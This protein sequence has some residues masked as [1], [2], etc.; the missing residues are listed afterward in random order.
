LS[1]FLVTIYK[2]LGY[3]TKMESPIT[4]V[5]LDVIGVLYVD[6]TDLYIMDRCIRSEYDLWQ[7]TQGATTSWGKLLLATGG[8]LKPEKCF[9]YMVDYEWQDDGSWEYSKLVDTLPPITVPL[10]D[11]TE[12]MIDHL[13][14][15]EARKT[16]GIWMNPAGTCDK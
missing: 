3:G 14:V 1:S 8:A 9:Y 16:L 11:G 7:E 10:S 4:R 13:P 12:A 15:E 6:D 5:W 2:N